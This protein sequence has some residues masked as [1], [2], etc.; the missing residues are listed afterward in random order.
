M[1]DTVVEE[2]KQIS[3]SELKEELQK[4]LS[5]LNDPQPGLFTWSGFLSERMQNL[6]GMTSNVL[7]HG[8]RCF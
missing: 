4:T 8:L 2:K 1:S 7:D 5:L 6:N 3:L